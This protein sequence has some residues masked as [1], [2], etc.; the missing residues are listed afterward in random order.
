MLALSALI[1]FSAALG[2]VGPQFVRL[3][4]DEVI[5]AGELRLFWLLGL[6]I[7]VFYLVRAAIGY[8]GMYLSFAFTQS[9]IADIRLRAYSRLLRLPILRFTEERSGSMVSRVV[10]DVNALEGM[11]QAGATRLAGQLFSILVVA[12]IL[13]WMNWKLATVNLIIAP[14]LAGIT[15]YYQEPLRQASRR[16]RS[17]VGEMTA[18]ASEVISNIQIVK[19][20]ANEPLEAAKFEAENNRY[21]NLNLDRRKEVGAMEAL[22]TLTSEYGVGAII[23]LG[24]WMVVTGALTLGE[25]TAFVLYQRQLQRPVISVMFFNNQ[26]QAG[27][28][29]LERVSDLLDATPET[30][31]EAAAPSAG[32]IQFDDV[33]FTYPGQ[34]DP[35]LTDLSF[36]IEAGET[37]A[38][39]GPSG[40]GKSSV[41][42]LLTRLYDPDSGRINIG[43]N[44]I[45]DLRLEALRKAIGVVPQE[46][47]LFS[48]SVRENIRYADPDASDSDVERAARLANADTFISDLPDGYDTEIGER[49]V[50]LSGGQK[51]RLAIARAIVKHARVL[52]LDEATASLDSESEAVIQDA[53]EG[54][55]ARGDGVTSVVIAH[56]L[57]TVRNAD[58]ILVLD[59][60]KL[61]EVGSH[62]QLLAV[63]GLY[64]RLHELQFEDERLLA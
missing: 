63:D 29:A 41:V 47:T 36:H 2:T 17:R 53:L 27:M 4:F 14:L 18:V 51:Q 40:A 21:V 59:H 31:G 5:P 32:D 15:R 22:I 6:A 49:G 8:A 48:G 46:P 50:K 34:V 62:E 10:S 12:T 44:D 9:I 52:V 57:S 16:I 42:K 7:L 54:L 37:V 35:A 61:V 45:R 25:L 19:S 20:F 33:T 64:R 11:I 26:L 24:G 55:F 1:S 38:L 13:V 30:E 43:G 23:L 58:R 60:G 56:R 3:A 28:A 39:V